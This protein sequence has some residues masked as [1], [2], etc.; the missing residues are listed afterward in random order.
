[1]YDYKLY[2]LYISDTYVVHNE[3]LFSCIYILF[4]HRICSFYVSTKYMSI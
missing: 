3:V 1:M 4:V 2:V